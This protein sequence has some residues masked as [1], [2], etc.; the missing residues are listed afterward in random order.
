S[1]AAD[2]EA[3]GVEARGSVDE[4]D[5]LRAVHAVQTA[6][7]DGCRS[8]RNRGKHRWRIRRGK[9]ASRHGRTDPRSHKRPGEFG[10]ASESAFR[11]CRPRLS[12]PIPDIV[13]GS[14]PWEPSGR[15]MPFAVDP[16]APGHKP[17]SGL[18]RHRVPMSEW[19][20]RTKPLARRTQ[21]RACC[22]C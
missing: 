15:A 19:R 11:G 17:T 2:G 4:I 9:Y 12:C 22:G 16:W 8:A 21:S 13:P 5:G 20:V 7:G 14:D 1:V 10:N 6:P 18:H 3:F